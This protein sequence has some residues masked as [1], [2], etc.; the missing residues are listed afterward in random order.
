[1]LFKPNNKLL[2]YNRVPI[3]NKSKSLSHIKN[4]AIKT[5]R[6]DNLKLFTEKQ[7]ESYSKKLESGKQLAPKIMAKYLKSLLYIERASL[8]LMDT[9]KQYDVINHITFRNDI[10]EIDQ[11]KSNDE[12]IV[13]K[14]KSYKLEN[15]LKSNVLYIITN[16]HMK[17][18]KPIY[19]VDNLYRGYKP[20]INKKTTILKEKIIMKKPNEDDD[21]IEI[22]VNDLLHNIVDNLCLNEELKQQSIIV[23]V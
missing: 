4:E 15:N 8:P 5:S 1:M 18:H 3:I 17:I 7:V 12:I 21:E 19:R 22:Y 16:L 11:E 13:I 6:Q 20:S 23:R 14:D 10:F 9:S 2:K